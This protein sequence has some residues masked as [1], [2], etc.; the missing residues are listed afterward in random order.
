MMPMMSS[1]TLFFTIVEKNIMSAITAIAPTKAATRTATKPVSEN[2]PA[3]MLPPRRS[4]TS[5][6]PSEAP[7][8]IPKMLGPARGLRNAV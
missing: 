2:D 4:I 3:V 7:L 1:I 6:T 5:A 8:L